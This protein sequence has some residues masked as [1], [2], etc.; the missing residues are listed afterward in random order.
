MPSAP[1]TSTV[2]SCSL[3][4]SKWACIIARN[5]SR[6][7]VRSICSTSCSGAF[8][9][10]SL[11]R[12]SSSF[13]MFRRDSQH[14]L[15]LAIVAARAADIR[16]QALPAGAPFEQRLRNQLRQIDQVFAA[17]KD[18]HPSLIGGEVEV[19][20]LVVVIAP[21]ADEPYTIAAAR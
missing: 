16:P 4:R 1:R 11:V 8:I 14:G 12:S 9:A 5:I 17:A 20:R 18:L 19:A 10:S 7:C 3:R 15:S 13:F 2:R 6:P 21:F